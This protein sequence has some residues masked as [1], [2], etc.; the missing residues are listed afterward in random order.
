MQV[1]NDIAY[2]IQRI[3]DI[4]REKPGKKTVQKMVYLMQEK[5][6]DLHCDYEL[7]F[8]GPYSA[9]LDIT[10]IRLSADGI[11]DFDYSGH[12]HRMSIGDGM[13]IVSDLPK[14]QRAV[15]DEVIS[16]YGEYTPSELELLTTTMYV[17]NYLDNRSADGI[18]QGVRKIKGTKYSDEEIK[19]AM[20]ELAYFG[21]TIQ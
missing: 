9:T 12:A 15:A 13:E 8:Y 18:V 14:N 5:G 11:V 21:K 7:H 3:S 16:R 1:T 6:V 19:K 17:Y 10:T 2:M 20:V 4:R